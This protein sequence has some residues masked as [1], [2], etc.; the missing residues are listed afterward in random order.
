MVLSICNF[1][2]SSKVDSLTVPSFVNFC[3][4]Q[5]SLH[6]FPYKC[7]I[8]INVFQMVTTSHDVG[9]EGHKLCLIHVTS[10]TI[11]VLNF[12]CTGNRLINLRTLKSDDCIRSVHVF[13]HYWFL[14]FVIWT[15]NYSFTNLF[16]TISVCTPR[17]RR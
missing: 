15:G 12:T 8:T 16:T 9:I 10:R 4:T 5:A 7:V 13:I 2:R 6:P 1:T 14:T 3:T 11:I 17:T